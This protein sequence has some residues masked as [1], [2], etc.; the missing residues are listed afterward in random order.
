M[1]G[2][3]G[4]RT[5]QGKLFHGGRWRDEQEWPL[6]RTQYTPYYLHGDGSLRI[7]LPAADALPLATILTRR[8]PYP[9]LAV[10]CARSWRCPPT[11][12]TS[13]P[14]GDV[15]SPLSP[16]CAILCH[17]ARITKRKTATL[18]AAQ[19]PYPRLADRPDVLVFQTEPLTNDVE[20]TGQIVVNLWIASSALDTDFTAKLLDVYPPNADY[21]DGYEMNLV[22]SIIR[23]RFRNGWEHEELMEPG[24]IYPVTSPFRPPAIFSRQVIAS[25]LTSPAA[26]SRASMS[27]P[28]QA[29]RSVATPTPSSPATVSTCD[30]GH[31]S[32]VVLPI[33]PAVG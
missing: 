30:R 8:I 10:A 31:P 21:P 7:E 27:T 28:T 4:H 2:G 16:A 9:P 1:G 3:D 29:N 5:P 17:W 11:M 26:T 6:A 18:F 20:V 25:A 13:T 22:D 32:H 23:T 14:C 19:P 12:A 33:V 24:Q 15:S